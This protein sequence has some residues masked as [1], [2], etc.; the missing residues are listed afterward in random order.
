[1]SNKSKGA[2]IKRFTEF[3]RT[4]TWIGEDKF[5]IDV[6]YNALDFFQKE[7]VD[8]YVSGRIGKKNITQEELPFD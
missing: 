3:T 8:A 6:S 5:I 7:I 4:Y 2:F 1:M